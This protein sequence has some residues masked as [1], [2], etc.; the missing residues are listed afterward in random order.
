MTFLLGQAFGIICLWRGPQ[1]LLVV[2][3]YP[4]GFTTF[5]SAIEQPALLTPI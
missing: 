1:L 2:P 4:L 3:A 5:L